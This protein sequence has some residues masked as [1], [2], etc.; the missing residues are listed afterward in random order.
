VYG[1]PP[2]DEKKKKLQIIF[3]CNY[4]GN[5]RA[6]RKRTVFISANW[7]VKIK[8]CRKLISFKVCALKSTQKFVQINKLYYKGP[9][10]NFPRTLKSIPEKLSSRKLDGVADRSSFVASFVA[11]DTTP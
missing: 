2:F 6:L 10:N 5:K 7:I 1:R 4:L 8:S 3:A 9:N 11:I